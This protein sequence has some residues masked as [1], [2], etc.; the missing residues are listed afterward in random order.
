VMTVAMQ[1]SSRLLLVWGVTNPVPES[2]VHWGYA[3]MVLSWSVV[4]I[5]RYAYYALNLIA[6]NSI[7]SVIT[8]LRYSLFMVLYPTGISGELSCIYQSLASVQKSGL[9]GLSMPNA[10]NFSFN[11]YYALLLILVL[12]VPGSPVMYGHMLHQR[13]KNLNPNAADDKKRH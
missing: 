13:K 7:P 10:L 12:Y 6:P 8:F 5:P 9:F 2:R 3:M 11:W 4:E 1:V